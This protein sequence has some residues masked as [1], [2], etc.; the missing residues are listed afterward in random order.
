MTLMSKY[1]RRGQPPSPLHT[2]ETFPVR[3]LMMRADV[4]SV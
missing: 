1:K 3:L 4:H 2:L